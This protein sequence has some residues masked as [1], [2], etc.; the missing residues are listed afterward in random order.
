MTV[1]GATVLIIHFKW[2]LSVQSGCCS[3][4][5]TELL[6]PLGVLLQTIGRH[7]RTNVL[8]S[9]EEV[10]REKEIV[11]KIESEAGK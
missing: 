7:G 11:R 1:C 5:D 8:Y 9:R 6:C 3:P 2:H 4:R 10:L